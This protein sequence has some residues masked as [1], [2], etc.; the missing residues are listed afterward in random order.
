MTTVIKAAPFSIRWY[1]RT[2]GFAGITLPPFGI[3]VLAERIDDRRLRRH[4]YCHW[5]QYQRMGFWGFYLKYL[6]YSVRYGYRNNPMEIEASEH[7]RQ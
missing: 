5:M 7:E 1:L 3:F 2:F 6:W 4:E